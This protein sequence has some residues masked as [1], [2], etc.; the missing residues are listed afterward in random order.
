MLHEA[1]VSYLCLLAL[2]LLY[3]TVDTKL[4]HNG[5]IEYNGSDTGYVTDATF[6][7]PRSSYTMVEKISKIL[8]F[9]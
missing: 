1:V 8:S 2:I 4:C 5:C 9:V 3:S 6:S 7:L